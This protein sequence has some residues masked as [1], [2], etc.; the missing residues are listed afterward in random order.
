MSDSTSPLAGPRHALLIATS[1]YSD[2]ELRQL[3]APGLDTDGLAEVLGHPWIGAFEVQT[4][5]N[6]PSGDLQE[7]IEEFCADRDPADQLLIYLS[8]H[9]ILDE[10]G[11]LYYAT[12]NTRHQR[13]AAT[14]VAAQWLN[15]RLDD[16][17]ARRQIII[18]DCCHSGAFARGAKGDSELD[19]KQRFRPNGRGRVVLT[20][21][22]ST[23]YSFERGHFSGEGVR[24]VFTNAIVEGLRSGDADRDKDGHITVSD[25]YQ[26]VFDTVRDAEPRQTPELWV[27]AGQGDLLIARSVRGAVIEPEPLPQD[28]QVT[29]ESPRARV[30]ETGVAELAE[31]IDATMPGLALTAKQVLEHISQEDLPRVAEIARAAL[32]APRGMAAEHVSQAVAERERREEQVRRRTSEERARRRSEEE[33]RR[34]AQEDARRVAQEAARLAV[35]QQQ[36]AREEARREA[37]ALARENTRREAAAAGPQAPSPLGGWRSR[38]GLQLAIILPVLALAALST[39]RIVGAL[40]SADAYADVSTLAALTAD[41]T[42]LAGALEA[43]RDEIVRFVALGTPTAAAPAPV[44][45]RGSAAPQS[46]DY[47]LE[48]RAIGQT[49]AATGRLARQVH[50]EASAIGSAYPAAVQQH[51]ANEVTALGNLADLRKAATDTRLPSLAIISQYGTI[52]NAVLGISDDVSLGRGDG[53]LDRAGHELALVADAREAVAEQS[54]ILTS[55]LASDL[56]VQSDFGQ[57]KLVAIEAALSQQKADLSVFQII[58]DPAQRQQYENALS[59]PQVTRA[60]VQEMQAIALAQSGQQDPTISE[61]GPALGYVR[62]SLGDVEARL[63]ATQQSR[64]SALHTD[65]I[66]SAAGYSLLLVVL[67]ALLLLIFRPPIRELPSLLRNV[68]T[69]L[70]SWRVTR[71]RRA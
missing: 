32:D 57:D 49:Y 65:A 25:L 17:R 33:A 19:L 69:R 44:A 62:T 18:L 8:C 42:G 39:L 54:A 10:N 66:L 30:R 71:L 68:R 2:P 38:R 67:A 50:A 37:E 48:Q 4:L 46:A 20:A 41:S 15:E 16:C 61:A 26:H 6:V 13:Q 64:A 5:R 34:K 55:A 9:G 63:E 14:A 70:G 47:K 29:L 56:T 36:Q 31:L 60:Q 52:I 40:G 11:R 53:D 35:L 22:R 23:E 24:S 58:A 27:Y 59:G 21:S 45:G 12:I 3:R 43:E 28:L 1:E 7:K 51:A